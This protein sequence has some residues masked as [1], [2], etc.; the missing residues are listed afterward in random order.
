MLYLTGLGGGAC[1]VISSA[2]TCE[3][4]PIQHRGMAQATTSGIFY[5]IG[6]ALAVFVASL[7][8]QSLNEGDWRMY[9]LYLSIPLVIFTLFVVTF[10]RESPRKNL[11]IGNFRLGLDQVHKLLRDDIELPKFH[12]LENRLR[13]CRENFQKLNKTKKLVAKAKTDSESVTK[14]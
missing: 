5:C 14:E 12:S 10:I 3:L 6:Y 4:V 7:T 11:L 9:Q 1:S 8:L 13:K 2:M